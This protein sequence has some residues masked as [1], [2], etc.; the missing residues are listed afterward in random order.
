MKRFWMPLLLS[1]MISLL[2]AAPAGA[3]GK[4]KGGGQ[5]RPYGWD[6]GEKRG[7]KSDTPPGRENRPEYREEDDRRGRGTDTDRDDRRGKDK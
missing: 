7:W 5:D 3:K 6:Q 1:A 4:G 2:I